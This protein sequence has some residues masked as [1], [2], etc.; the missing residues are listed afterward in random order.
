MTD[1]RSARRSV[2]PPAAGVAGPSESTRRPLGELLL[3]EGLLS[4]AELAA[5]LSDQASI[6]LPLGQIMVT[7]GY[8]SRPTLLRALASQEN[9]K[10]DLERGFATGLF[11]A[12]DQ[13]NRSRR[14]EV[15]PDRAHGDLL[16]LSWENEGSADDAASLSSRLRSRLSRD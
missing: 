5:A 13:R 11:D 9:G 10:L 1:N 2:A 7:R 3:S 15:V 14:P 6:G 4:K 8:L 16:R 12:I